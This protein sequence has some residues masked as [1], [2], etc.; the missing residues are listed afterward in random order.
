VKALDFGAPPHG[1]LA[2]GMDR[3]VSMILGTASI[4][5]VTAFPKNRSAFCPLTRAPSPVATEQLRELGLLDMGEGKQI[6]GIQEGRDLIDSLSWVSRIGVREDERPAILA[7]LE[8]AERLAERVTGRASGD[9][10]LFSPWPAANRMR[11]QCEARRCAEE[12]I[13]EIFRNAPSV[14]G[15]FFKVASVL[16]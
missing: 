2:L 16:E 12:V 6:A 8:D 10:P 4:R 7:A 9:E 11:E 1:G 13:A 3:V 5:E 15:D 14:K